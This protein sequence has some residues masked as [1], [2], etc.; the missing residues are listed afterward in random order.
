MKVLFRTNKTTET[1]KTNIVGQTNADGKE[2]DDTLRTL[3]SDGGPVI[4]TK[5]GDMVS[6]TFLVEAR[7]KEVV[8]AIFTGTGVGDGLNA[9]S[10][11]TD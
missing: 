8:K 1:Q 11:D 7:D 4:K 6:A 2:L 3:A 5:A 9:Q 10:I